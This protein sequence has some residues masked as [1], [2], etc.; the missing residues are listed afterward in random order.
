MTRIGVF[1]WVIGDTVRGLAAGLVLSVAGGGIWCATRL[2]DVA[3][4]LSEGNDRRQAL[5]L[6]FE[7]RYTLG[8]IAQLQHRDPAQIARWLAEA[9][10]KRP[11]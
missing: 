4:R 2:I 9:D 10:R 6:H 8:Q 1:A 3:F 11:S 7:Q 5:R